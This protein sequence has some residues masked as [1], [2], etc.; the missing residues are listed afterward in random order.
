LNLCVETLDG[1]R[2]HSWSRPS[3]FTPEG[4]VT[5]IADRIA[6]CAHDLED[7]VSADVVSLDTLPPQVADFCGRTR[8]KQLRAFIND[9]VK[10]TH[11][12]GVVGLSDEASAALAALRAFNYENIYLRPSS[13]EQ[14]KSVISLLGALVE[15]YANH[16]KDLPGSDGLRSS[17]AAT[18]RRA[19]EYVGGMTDKFAC[20]QATTLLNWP[21]DQLPRGLGTRA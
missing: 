13:I 20:M 2:N 10:T 19:V 5:G 18:V 14:G 3:P 21:A 9:V 1:I 4:Q 6:Y 16:P 7:A 12:Y 15:H 8:S 17:D 11:E